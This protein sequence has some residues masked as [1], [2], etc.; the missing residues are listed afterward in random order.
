MI[1]T[2][3]FNSY[4][5]SFQCQAHFTNETSPM[6]HEITPQ[7][8]T[9]MP[10]DHQPKAR[11]PFLVMLEIQNTIRAAI[12]LAAPQ[13]S[14]SHHGALD[15]CV[16]IGLPVG[17]IS[18]TTASRSPAVL[19]A[20][21]I[22]LADLSIRQLIRA[23]CE[24]ALDLIRLAPFYPNQRNVISKV[25]GVFETA[26]YYIEPD[27]DFA[28]THSSNC[29]PCFSPRVPHFRDRAPKKGHITA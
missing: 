21:E 22:G 4:A 8:A 14:H 26:Q 5:F 12:P 18:A 3:N 15:G 1:K 20:L 10:T 25:L 2:R 6:M 7:K 9:I 19:P 13:S 29:W 16:G 27:E 17:D 23:T 24:Y 11:A 28:F